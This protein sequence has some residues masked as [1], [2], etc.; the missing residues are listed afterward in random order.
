MC[1]VPRLGLFS[2]GRLMRAAPLPPD[3]FVTISVLEFLGQLSSEPNAS[4]LGLFLKGLGATPREAV[5]AIF[6]VRKPTGGRLTLRDLYCALSALDA[7]KNDVIR[8]VLAAAHAR[9]FDN[10][11]QLSAA[12]EGFVRVDVTP[13]DF[14]DTLDDLTSLDLLEPSRAIPVLFEHILAYVRCRFPGDKDATVQTMAES[15]FLWG[16]HELAARTLF[17]CSS[18]SWDIKLSFI[19]SVSVQLAEKEG[20]ESL[21][22]FLGLF[23]GASETPPSDE[24]TREIFARLPS[25]KGKLES[26]IAALFNEASYPAKYTWQPFQAFRREDEMDMRYLNYIDLSTLFDVLV[27]IKDPFTGQPSVPR[28]D[29]FALFMMKRGIQPFKIISQF[30]HLVP[31]MA[32]SGQ[33]IRVSGM[34]QSGQDTSLWPLAKY[35]VDLAGDSIALISTTIAQ[36][37]THPL[38]EIPLSKLGSAVQALDYLFIRLDPD[39]LAALVVGALEPDMEQP[40]GFSTAL[41]LHWHLTP[42]ATAAYREH[43]PAGS[44]FAAS[45]FLV[46]FIVAAHRLLSQ[47][48]PSQTQTLR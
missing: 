26:I 31:G 48:D 45:D 41:I 22:F 23:K 46:D 21:W 7:P 33:V 44:L 1:R 27:R 42:S 3:S 12:L 39:S 6:A 20:C 4:Y 36:S 10:I 13:A 28:L 17:A 19:Q 29:D 11:A 38:S 24:T 2:L 40:A 15:T 8:A 47:S 43:A 18:L 9:D 5:G 14:W 34:A 30:A 35:L 32:Q 16:H 25:S 37:C